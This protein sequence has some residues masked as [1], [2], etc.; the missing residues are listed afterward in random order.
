MNHENF[1]KK[2]LDAITVTLWCNILY[3]LFLREKIFLS[4]HKRHFLEWLKRRN[5]RNFLEAQL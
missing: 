1:V 3:F 4:T 2:K 5:C